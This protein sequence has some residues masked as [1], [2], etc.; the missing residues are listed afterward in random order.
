MQFQF[1]NLIFYYDMEK[2]NYP[3][4]NYMSLI[5]SATKNATFI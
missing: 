4:I 5:G 3:L 1:L 2:N